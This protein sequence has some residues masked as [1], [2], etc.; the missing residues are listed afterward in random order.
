MKLKTFPSFSSLNYCDLSGWGWSFIG[1]FNFSTIIAATTFLQSPPSII[2]SQALPCDVHFARKILW[3]PVLITSLRLV[4]LFQAIIDRLL[5]QHTHTRISLSL[6]PPRMCIRITNYN[7]KFHKLINRKIIRDLQ[8]KKKSLSLIFWFYIKI[9][10]I[11]L[12]RANYW[13]WI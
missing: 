5:H 11:S 3:C 1:N 2:Q 7:K 4:F 8:E 10:T 12:I 6:S 13:T 9:H